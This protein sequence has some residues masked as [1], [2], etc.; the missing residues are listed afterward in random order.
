M[1]KC[2]K[3]GA[4]LNEDCFGNENE[5]ADNNRKM[6]DN[7]QGMDLIE[8]PECG[9]KI[10]SDSRICSYCGYPLEEKKD[11]IM[12]PECGKEI[13]LDIET[14]PFCGYPFQTKRS[15]ENLKNKKTIE[16]RKTI[17]KILSVV[18]IIAAIV[19]LLL[20]IRS[21]AKCEHEYDNG[22]ITKEAS[23]TEEGEKTFTC[24]HC[25]ETKIESVPVIAHTYKEEVTKEPTF[26]EEGEKT[27]TC[28]SCGN[29]YTENIPV[30]DDEVVVSV[31]DK[32]NLPKDSNAGRYS[33]RIE[34]IFDVMNR[35]D[36]TIRG[37]QGNLLVND[38]FGEQILIMTCDFTGNSIPAGGSITITDLGM[39]VNEFIDE[40][41]KFYNTDFS[42]LK[43]EYEIKNIVYDDGSSKKEQP[44]K[45]SIESQKVI[46]N[47]TDKQNLDINYREGR[48]SPRVE[49]VFEVHNNTS[50]DIQGVQGI[51]TIKDLF[52]VD[53]MSATLDFTGQTIPA[54]EKVVFEDMGID[55]N[56]FV[57]KNVKVY[58]TKYKD[59]KFEY[60]V[61]SIVYSDGTT[62]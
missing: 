18:I 28:E 40:H 48:Y 38:L 11:L 50:K 49:F 59:L 25:D 10:L 39:D 57:D 53:I 44:S 46:V 29:S 1:D 19:D 31:T 47:V 21:C 27:F 15:T 41:V 60:K 24:I 14:C 42:D 20:L 37:V 55:V 13:P 54:S 7:N 9:K 32:S 2:E 52:G 8:C 34:L 51:F 45:E 22:I 36:K 3:C 12:C 23:C 30:R 5:N 17:N 62:E 58:T 35:T 43:F 6:N 56:Q 33:D 61:S 16:S 26:D 4:I